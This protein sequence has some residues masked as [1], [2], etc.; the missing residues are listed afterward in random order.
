M[1][2]VY[3]L[4]N[5]SKW[6]DN[7]LRY[8]LRSLVHNFPDL[9]Q[10]WILG[11]CPDWLTGVNHLPVPSPYERNKDA[12][13]INAILFACLEPELSDEF[14]FMS[15]DQVL[16]KPMRPADF[17]PWWVEDM[18]GIKT[19]GTNRYKMR[20]KA[21]FERLQSQGYS[22]YNFEGHVPYIHKKELFPR[23]MYAQNYGYGYGYTINTVYFNQW[24]KPNEFPD[25]QNLQVNKV[26]AGFFQALPLGQ[27]AE[28]LA[29]K[30]FL[31][32]DDSGLTSGL[33]A[34]LQRIF[35]E[36][37]RFEADF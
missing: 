15:D 24:L 36:P 27:E 20:L 4:A 22:T 34:T 30:T 19:W 5:T 28:R 37:S 29:G 1:D 23:M 14:L 12:N 10:V 17:R 9:E 21:T 18:A 35:P 11:H 13:L 26:R 7:E 8:S 32:Y 31:S 25:F 16:L 2:A 3:P 33:K 6:N